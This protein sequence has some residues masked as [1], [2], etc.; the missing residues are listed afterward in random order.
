MIKTA[1]DIYGR[2]FEY[3]PMGKVAGRNFLIKDGFTICE[4]PDYMKQ[5]ERYFHYNRLRGA[6]LGESHI[7]TNNRALLV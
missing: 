2:V 5:G 6:W 1:N 4:N 3:L 7:I